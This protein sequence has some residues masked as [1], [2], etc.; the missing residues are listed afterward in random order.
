MTRRLRL[1]VEI[2]SL[3][4]TAASA[5]CSVSKLKTVWVAVFCG[6]IHQRPLFERDGFSRLFGNVLLLIAL[7]GVRLCSR[8]TVR[9]ADTL[10]KKPESQSNNQDCHG[11]YAFCWCR[12]HCTGH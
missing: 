1:A 9:F 12:L 5:A 11:G 7:A 10:N 4:S 2:R 3:N 8:F 6:L